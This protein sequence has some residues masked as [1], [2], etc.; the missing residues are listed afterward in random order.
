MSKR[1]F[2]F[3]TVSLHILLFCYLAFEFIKIGFNT[4]YTMYF[5]VYKVLRITELIVFE[6]L[7]LLFLRKNT[8]VECYD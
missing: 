1:G 5:M 3:G 7:V 6:Q 8:L 4:L 2:E